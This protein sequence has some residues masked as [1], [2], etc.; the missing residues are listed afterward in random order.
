VNSTTAQVIAASVATV[1]AWNANTKAL[2][3]P[4]DWTHSHQILGDRIIDLDNALGWIPPGRRTQDEDPVVAAVLRAAVE[5]VREWDAFVG[6]DTADAHQDPTLVRGR[7]CELA[8]AL[9]GFPA[10]RGAKVL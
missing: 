10:H 4:G 3:R 7:V 6:T 8:A 9:R 5:M 1:K 2:T